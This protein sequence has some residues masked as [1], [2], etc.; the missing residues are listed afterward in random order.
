MTELRIDG[1]VCQLA[2]S[3]I[4][5]PRYNASKLRSIKAWREGGSVELCVVATPDVERL[6]CCAG[7]LH[8]AEDFNDSY[9]V[10]SLYVDGVELFSGRVILLGVEHN[11]AGNIYRVEIRSGGAEWAESAAVTR[12][13]ESAVDCS[14]TMT[15]QGIEQSWSDSGAV[16]M[17]PLRR[18]SYPEPE[19]TGLY[20]AQQMLFP[21]DYHPFISVRKVIESIVE[22]SG[23]TLHSDFVNSALCDKLMISGAYRRPNV[24]AAYAQMG[25]KAMRS[26]STTATAGDSGRVDAWVPML[27]SNVGA[28]V[29]TV[30]PGV[31]DEDGELLSEAFS[32]GGCF[33]MVSGRPQFVPR[34]EISAAF[35]IHLRYT[36][37]YRITSSKQLT[38]F[39]RIYV[40]NECYVDLVLQNPHK[41]MRGDI[42]PGVE[43]KLFIFDYDATAEY[44]IVGVGDINSA[45]STIVF[46]ESSARRPM[47]YKRLAGST[48]FQQYFGDWAIYDGYVEERGRREVELTIRTPFEVC[49]PTSPKVF[50]D[51]YFEGAEAGQQLTLRSRC[52]ITPVFS[53]AVGYGEE[54]SF[55]DVANI[56]ISQADLLEAIAQMF[57]LRLYTHRPSRTIYIEPYEDFY[58]GEV[59]DWRAR[60]CG[61][62]IV[63]TECAPESY[64]RVKLGYQ[65]ADG[66]AARITTGEGKELGTWYGLN[67]SYAAKHAIESRLNPL[68]H[69][70]ASFSGALSMAP[71]AEILTVGDRD[72]LAVDDY[73]EPRVVLYHG[74]QKLPSGEFWPTVNDSS[75][76][77]YAAFC[78]SEMGETLTFDDRDGCVGLHRYYTAELREMATRQWLTAKVVIHPEEYVDLFDPSTSGATI[79]SLF[80][81]GI[82]GDSSLFRLDEI[83][84]YDMVS[85]VAECRF[86]RILRD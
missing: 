7:D 44:R 61:E 36:T 11:E 30:N 85:H 46:D 68:F 50:N 54:L 78:S 12:L 62:G 43:Y 35:D 63:T 32:N 6:M 82:G 42:I 17:L 79:R 27:A 8:R 15:M 76:Y 80:R 4:R 41:D 20:V 74:L 45:V 3:D 21:Q 13:K 31:E 75:S 67:D 53:G 57:N 29:D 26:C 51:I 52:S 77:P 84:S 64:E 9:H 49:T 24:E 58:D 19:P 70:T 34:R 73:V 40:G 1:M 66:A 55:E 2:N 47:L 71:S 60:L 16:C 33:K 86:Q 65:P 37:D 83:S 25:F 10:A 22:E 5:L 18:D 28:I 23:Y 81:L 39:D 48:F 14:V 72:M 59:Y 69:P 56:D 38:G